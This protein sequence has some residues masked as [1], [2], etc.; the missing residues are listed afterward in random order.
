MVTSASAPEVGRRTALIPDVSAGVLELFR[1]LI[2]AMPDAIVVVDRT[3]SI[4]LL[5]GQTERLFGYTR[6][7]LLGKP[8]DILVPARSRRAHRVHRAG[9]F[10]AASVRPMGSGMELRA[11]RRDG[12]E[13]PVEISLSPLDSTAGTLVICA[14]RDVSAQRAAQRAA[15]RARLANVREANERLVVGAIHAQAAA[16]EARHDSHLKDEFLATV[17]HELRTPLNA[18]MGW[19]RLLASNRLPSGRAE[20]A[21][22]AIERSTAT[23]ARMVDDL[24]DGA[25]IVKGTLR[26]TM[27]PLDLV[28][29]VE[30]ALDGVRPQAAGG[31]VQLTFDPPA[32]APAVRGD[33][34]RLQQVLVNLLANAIKFTPAGGRVSVFVESAN[35]QVDVRVVDTGR[36]ISSDLLPHVFER[37][38]Q[39]DD[40]STQRH[41]G[42]GLGLNI[43]LE[44]VT[45]HGG[46]VH[47]ASE[48]A[49]CG[50]TFTVRLPIL[51]PAAIAGPASMARR[52]VPSM[53]TPVERV[54]RLD[55]LRVLVFGNNTDGRAL[56][57]LALTQAGASVIAVSSERDVLS[58]LD[59]EPPDALVS[60]IDVSGDDGCAL[61]RQIRARE[62][63]RGGFLP[64]IAV[65]AYARAEDRA[66]T[67][68]AGFQVHAAKPVDPVA[69]AAA[70]AAITQSVHT[71]KT[72]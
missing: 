39:A 72:D 37:F 18:I 1:A 47:A 44:L 23:L 59:V 42:L 52:V 56:T 13:F 5:N 8:V 55:G 34:A 3:S 40:A 58:L 11:A 17:S 27:Q 71:A 2:E 32:D 45:L 38:R 26:L 33:A 12:Q 50:S 43:V 25:R 70:V 20:H 54:P 46:S 6:D 21:I 49:G 28:A 65:T 69:L 4:T 53:S 68:A 60:D 14:I 67:L 41:T 24:L 64:A 57:S 48:G 62:A 7:E 10:R 19:T 66:R 63:E 29:V 51:G 22:A 16:D 9:F 30:A 31:N 35:D 36:G 61:I 15:E